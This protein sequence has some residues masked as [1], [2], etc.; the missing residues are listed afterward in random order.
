M[1]ESFFDL[2]IC[3]Q[4]ISFIVAPAMEKRQ[5]AIFQRLLE[6]KIDRLITDFLKIRPM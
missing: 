2:I 1:T 6:I 5:Q 3:L 4:E